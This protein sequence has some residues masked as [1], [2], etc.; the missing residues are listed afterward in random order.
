MKL[1]NKPAKTT[2]TPCPREKNKSI[3]PA[4]NILFD[5]VAKPIIPANIGVE[6]GLEA[7]ANNEP[8]KNGYKNRLVELP[9]GIFLTIGAILSSTKPN[10][11]KPKINIKEA[12]NKTQ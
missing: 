8:T 11:F 12:T 5:K 9:F 1:A 6:Q 7:K 3:K 4:R 2:I 10:E